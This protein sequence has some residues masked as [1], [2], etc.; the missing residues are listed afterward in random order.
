M[1]PRRPARTDRALVTGTTSR[2]S[3][4]IATERRTVLDLSG[5]V[6]CER[7]RIRPPLFKAV[8]AWPAGRPQDWRIEAV[9]L[10]GTAFISGAANV[11]AAQWLRLARRFVAASTPFA[12]IIGDVVGD[13]DR[14]MSGRA[15]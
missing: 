12:E 15:A 14:E 9:S 4:P 5:T 2:L 6:L 8:V 3:R 7:P 1:S 13:R 10:D 11:E